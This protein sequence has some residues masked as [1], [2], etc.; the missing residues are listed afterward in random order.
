MATITNYVDK[1]PAPSRPEE[2]MGIIAV[3]L[4][5]SKVPASSGDV[6]QAVN[7]PADTLVTEVLVHQETPEGAT[8]TIDVGD[9]SNADGWLD[10]IDINSST[11]DVI[12]SSMKNAGTDEAYGKK[13]GKWYGSADTIDVTAN[14]NLSTAVIDII[15]KYIRKSWSYR[16]VE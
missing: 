1:I 2:G 5:F 8:A 7:I 6:I 10:G 3:R 4:D 11:T 12:Y 13:G 9:G 15:V 14:A 16:N